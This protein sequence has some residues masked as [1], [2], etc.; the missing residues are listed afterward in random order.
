MS[1][2]ADSTTETRIRDNKH[3]ASLLRRRLES[4]HA[5]GALREM[6]VRMSDE[7]LVDVWL[8]NEQQ[9]RKH[10]AKL[11]AEKQ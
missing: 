10:S 2:Q 1:T 8:R 9:G 6:L 11:R 7:E 3:F 4:R 5:N